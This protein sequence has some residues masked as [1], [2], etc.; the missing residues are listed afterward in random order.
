[1][2]NDTDAT[3]LS[4]MGVTVLSDMGGVRV[5]RVGRDGVGVRVAGLVTAC[6]S[7]RVCSGCAVR[8]RRV[9]GQVSTR[10]GDV[11]HGGG[12]VRV[13]WVKRRWVCSTPGCARGSFTEVV[14][15]IPPGARTRGR[16]R[17]AA[18]RAVAEG[19]RTVAQSARD[20][21]L[22]WSVVQR[23]FQAYA[24]QVLP[25]PATGSFA[26]GR[27]P[28]Q[29]APVR[30]QPAGPAP[31]L[32]A[33][34]LPA[35]VRAE[36]SGIELVEVVGID[37]V[38][39]GPPRWEQ[40]PDTGKWGLV[41]DRWHAGFV[42]ISG[43]GGL[44]GQVEGR[45]G[46]CVAGWLSAQP[47]AWRDGV[48][49]VAIGMCPAFRAA[50]RRALPQ[51]TVVVDCFHVVQLAHRRLAELR[52]RCTRAL[53]RRRGRR[54]DPEWE[55][56]APLRR[57]AE[58]PTETGHQKLTRTLTDMGTYDQ[59]ILAGWQAKEK[60]PTL[61]RLTPKHAHTHPDR[62]AISH[63]RY[64][65]TRHC[66]GLPPARA[67][68]PRPDHQGMVGRHPSLHPDR[69]HQRR[70]RRQQPSH[71]TRSS[72]RLRLPQPPQPTTPITLRNHPPSPTRNTPRLSPKTRN[73]A[74][75]LR[76]LGSPDLCLIDYQLGVPYLT[77]SG[78]FCTARGRRWVRCGLAGSRVGL[79]LW[80]SHLR[81]RWC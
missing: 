46:A 3:V 34:A 40:D 56:H 18:G 54:S 59:W 4:D 39:R 51:A 17:V 2:I 55:I 78:R 62:H 5:R 1:M 11:D 65:F 32:P 22:S 66:I 7:V 24:E 68:Q 58:D 28:G 26:P 47:P 74:G 70:Q 20:H 36:G 53:R 71:P 12:R 63:A 69:D 61:L 8:A 38:R 21:G 52:R 10:P 37:E 72:Q 64:E 49:Y 25:V 41:L 45:T 16:L 19:G 57:N 73:N 35:P 6:E 76:R 27:Q 30:E 29:C 81:A 48:R 23:E 60:L 50:L 75:F 33:P 13:E 79:Q 42:G 31:A 44:L 77:K 14:P 80:R 67:H 15:Q 9:K 43:R